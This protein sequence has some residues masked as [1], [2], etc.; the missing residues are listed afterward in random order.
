[1]KSQFF[2]FVF[3]GCVGFI[4]DAGVVFVLSEAGISPVLARIPSLAAAIFTTWT[5][6]RTLTFRVKA[7]KS[8]DEVVR[9]AAVA[10]SAAIMNFLLYT[11]LVLID[12]WPVIAVALSTIV[13]L[14]YSFFGYRKFAFRP[15]PNADSCAN[16]DT[17]E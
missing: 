7:P 6:N 12:V 13:L 8:R 2:R 4:I 11:A 3:V 9:Y 10:L 17:L 14:F 16:L 5:L 15:R 1:M